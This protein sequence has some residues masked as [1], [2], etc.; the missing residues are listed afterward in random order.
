MREDRQAPATEGSDPRATD[1][2]LL[3]AARRGDD[4]AFGELIDRHAAG[5]FRL[6]F[7]L[8]GNSP[9]AEDVVQETLMGAFEHLGRFRERSSVKTWLSRI[10]VRQAARCHRR[11]ARKKVTAL[12][13]ADIGG[14]RTFSEDADRRLDVSQALSTLSHAHREVVVLR[15]FEGMSYAEMAEVIGVPRGT[16]ESRLHRARQ[17][18]GELLRDYLS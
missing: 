7:R 14:R 9:D 6:A 8:V 18:L 17:E 5:L 12:P 15:E 13:E 11:R 4:R 2:D 16:V 1:S 10:L 3:A